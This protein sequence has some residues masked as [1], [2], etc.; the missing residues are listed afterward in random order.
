MT[1]ELNWKQ[2][3]N[4]VF[5]ELYSEAGEQIRFML[6]N[7]VINHLAGNTPKFYIFYIQI[8][9]EEEKEYFVDF[10]TLKSV[11]SRQNS[12]K[13]TLTT[14]KNK[15]KNIKYKGLKTK[16][17]Y[18]I[19]RGESFYERFLTDSGWKRQKSYFD[20]YNENEISESF[21]N[22]TANKNDKTSPNANLK[23]TTDIPAQKQQESEYANCPNC[24]VVINS[25]FDI[26]P[27]CSAENFKVNDSVD[28]MV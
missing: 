6:E 4:E 12:L 23:A 2:N 7:A 5:I 19:A 14:S 21:S 18:S 3:N 15:S 17:M 27:Y 11:S 20:L 10:N 22:K 28:V 9:N 16:G 1:Q 26:C 8:E 24:N 13:V 25:K